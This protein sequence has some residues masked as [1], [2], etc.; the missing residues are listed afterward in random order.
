MRRCRALGQRDAAAR[1]DGMAAVS[2][3]S[4]QYACESGR[5]L[6]AIALLLSVVSGLLFGAV[7]VKQ[8]LRTGAYQIIK[9]GTTGTLGRRLSARACCLACKLRFVPCSS[10]L[11]SSLCAD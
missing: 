1:A 5:K 10:L 7:L 2:A 9:S 8:V 6:Y 3:I 11:R 4:S